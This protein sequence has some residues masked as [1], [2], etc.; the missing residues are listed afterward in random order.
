MLNFLEKIYYILK[1]GSDTMF[2]GHTMSL[3]TDLNMVANCINNIDFVTIAAITAAGNYPDHP[4]IYNAGI[5][6]PPTEILMAWADGNDLIMQN[7]YPA[8]LNSKEPDDMIVALIA[9]M[10]KKNIIIYIPYDEFMVYGQIL[11]NHI[12]YTYGIT[13]NY[14]NVPFSINPANIPYIISKFYMMDLMEPM[15]Y[16]SMYPSNQPLPNFVINKLAEEVRPFN[17]PATYEE[18]VAYFNNLNAQQQKSRPQV[19]MVKLV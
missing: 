5:L 6:M 15:V 11:L 10:T 8:Y 4:N 12:Y 1:K 13:C 7:E 16:I 18:Y 14:M 3:V 2:N 17:R 19:N 9:A